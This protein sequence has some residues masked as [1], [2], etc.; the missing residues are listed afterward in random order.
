MLAENRL[1]L[2]REI[3]Y[4]RILDPPQHFLSPLTHASP[5]DPSR[6][7]TNISTLQLLLPFTNC[8]YSS[9]HHRQQRAR[10]D[11][12][13]PATEP[14]SPVRE[15]KPPPCPPP[16]PSPP[17]CLPAC[18]PARRLPRPQPRPPPC[19]RAW[20]G[21]R[22]R[23][24]RCFRLVPVWLVGWPT[25]SSSS[26]SFS[27]RSLVLP[28]SL[29]LW[30]SP[31][32]FPSLAY[33]LLL[34]LPLF[35]A[36]LGRDSTTGP[37]HAAEGAQTQGRRR[38]PSATIASSPPLPCSDRAP[39]SA[40]TSAPLLHSFITIPSFLHLFLRLPERLSSLHP[41]PHP[42][43]PNNDR[44]DPSPPLSLSLSPA[45]LSRPS[46]SSSRTGDRGPRLP[47]PVPGLRL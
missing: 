30:S 2:R 12:P 45:S 8:S 41:T 31:L 34:F 44:T 16:P 38:Q 17:A 13:S 37:A 24:S 22:L 19:P 25:S 9:R 10:F 39:S 7:T 1:L 28:L 18:L 35:M 32:G 23:S 21:C 29:S 26:S 11:T 3:I 47:R 36:H 27:R 46:S 40:S 33:L 43:Q 4:S 14:T 20:T 15:K 6:R 42:T 5:H